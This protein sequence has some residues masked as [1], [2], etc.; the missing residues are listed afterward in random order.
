MLQYSIF[1]ADRTR[2][3]LICSLITATDNVILL[4]PSAGW[5]VSRIVQDPLDEFQEKWGVRF[6]DGERAP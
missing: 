4:R 3:L 1:M 5:F 6:E 2:V